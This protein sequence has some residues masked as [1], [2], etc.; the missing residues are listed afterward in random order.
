MTRATSY[1]SSSFLY[2]SSYSSSSLISFHFPCLNTEN[3]KTRASP[4]SNTPLATQER[5]VSDEKEKNCLPARVGFPSL[6][7]WASKLWR[8][9]G[10][11][12]REK[13]RGSSER[14]CR[15]VGSSFARV[16][17]SDSSAME[18]KI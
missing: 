3:F 4:V 18:G 11:R 17:E 7:F 2:R 10:D 1:A 13:L 8:G 16:G 9:S 15:G 6:G 5:K 12:G 14:Y